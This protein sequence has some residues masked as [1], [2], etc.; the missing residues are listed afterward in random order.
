MQAS[1]MKSSGRARERGGRSAGVRPRVLAAIA[2][3]GLLAC[4]GAIRAAD[5]N[6][7]TCHAELSRGKVVHA[8]L[9][10]G[11]AT[12]HAAIDTSAV[13]HK[14][15]GKYAKGLSAPPGELCL[16]CHDKQDF[17]G[18]VTHA[19]VAAEMCTGCHNPHASDQ[20]GLLG[21]EPA[22]LCLDCHADVKKKPHL[23]VGFTSSGHPL[24]D[25]KRPGQVADPLRKEK[26]FSCASCH[27][28]HRS[29]RPKLSRFDPA[30]GMA[31]CQRCHQ[32]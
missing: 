32:K 30:A 14:V 6:C 18:K 17:K 7:E 13:P 20:Q 29:D 22:K 11:C 1:A 5:D 31:Y 19:P 16:T 3:L 21:K 8:A 28:P 23:V 24:G 27:E 10:N 9:G 26:P 25:E 15:T 2:F 12:C 4:A